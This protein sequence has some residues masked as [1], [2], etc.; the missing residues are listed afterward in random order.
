[1]DITSVVER[2]SSEA[3]LRDMD[4]S[5]DKEVRGTVTG[6]DRGSGN[7]QS[8]RDTARKKQLIHQ[9]RTYGILSWSSVRLPM[10]A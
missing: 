5:T 10:V 4:I 1:V 6:D 3:L 9:S 2:T 7:H 8:S